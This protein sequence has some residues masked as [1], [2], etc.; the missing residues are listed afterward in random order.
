MN[1]IDTENLYQHQKKYY[2]KLIEQK[3][4]FKSLIC[5]PTGGGKT[6][7]AVLYLINNQLNSNK[8]VL[9]IAHS[10]FLLDQAY[11][12]FESFD[13][14]KNKMI[15]IHSGEKGLSFDALNSGYDVVMITSQSLR[16][17]K[18][19]LFDILGEDTVIVID[20]A[21]HLMA[22]KYIGSIAE[23]SNNKTVLG[24]TATPIRYKSEETTALNVYFKDDL[25]VRIHMTQL[26]E[27]K[28]LVKP[29][30]E[31]V[32]YSLNNMEVS[33]INELE[34]SLSVAN[35][36][37]NLIVNQY[38]YNY[39]KYGKTV[40]FALDVNHANTLYEMF[41]STSFKDNVYIV[42][43]KLKDN[44]SFDKFKE[45]SNG[46][47]I[48]V[49]ILNEGVDIPDIQSIFLTKP[50]NSKVL[51]TQIVGRAL[52][53]SKGK[54]HANV[55]NFAVSNIGKKLLLVTPK[56]NYNLYQAQWEN[57]QEY[58]NYTR[59]EKNEHII[60]EILSNHKNE[61]VATK[62]GFLDVFLVGEYNLI[63][64]DSV[65]MIIPVTFSDYIATESYINKSSN[66]LPQNYFFLENTDQ[67]KES[68]DSNKDISF[69]PYDIELIVAIENIEELIKD[70]SLRKSNLTNKELDSEIL[71]W[72]NDLDL[73]LKYYL[74]QISNNSPNKF[75]MLIRKQLVK[76]K[77]R[78]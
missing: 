73:N 63:E 74:N 31:E 12:T 56:E 76:Y 28:I 27:E 33:N 58:D 11:D 45:C 43:S 14:P 10:K 48:N 60:E 51:V 6:R 22:E 26:F 20:E 55:V 35:N 4:N 62:F 13:Y 52:R 44:Q 39:E 17:H 69:K 57:S 15:C 72:Y 7:L 2:D 54:T 47:L 9:W 75:T 5:I 40:I 70:L 8:K 59:K 38:I 68:I 42:H 49:N 3:T 64:S 1:K 67:L 19:K 71:N 53:K 30:F 21:H 37:N 46:I 65:D 24:L 23:F 61:T 41:I 66:K 36:Y 50:L 29:I 78:K 34:K 77:Y 16:I 32:Y 25:G 18:T